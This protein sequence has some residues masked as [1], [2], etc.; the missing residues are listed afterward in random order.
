MTRDSG[1]TR[2]G[3][4]FNRETTKATSSLTSLNTELTRRRLNVNREN[5]YSPAS[6]TRDA[7]QKA[8]QNADTEF[9]FN[10]ENTD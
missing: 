3:L 4:L 1:Q 2:M 10:S 7:F 9:A 8:V 5:T 6:L